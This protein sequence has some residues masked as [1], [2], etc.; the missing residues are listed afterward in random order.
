MRDKILPFLIFAL[1]VF[2]HTFFPTIE[3][4]KKNVGD[5]RHNPE[6][7]DDPHH[8]LRRRLLALGL[9]PNKPFQNLFSASVIFPVK[10][11]GNRPNIPKPNAAR[12]APTTRIT[13]KPIK[14]SNI[15]LLP[16]CNHG[17]NCCCVLVQSNYP[18]HLF[19]VYLLALASLRILLPIRHLFYP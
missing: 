18:R 14:I 10:N 15:T 1:I 4:S 11:K 6:S 9:N 13:I 7:Y 12:K 5:P 19:A 8:Y 16:E 17:Q 3:I 2:A